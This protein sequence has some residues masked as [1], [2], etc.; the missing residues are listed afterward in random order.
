MDTTGISNGR[1]YLEITTRAAKLHIYNKRPTFR[2]RRVKPVM[3]VEK[4]APTFKVNWLNVR[5]QTGRASALRMAEQQNDE[6]YKK[7]M[8]AIAR[9]SQKGDRLMQIQNK[10]NEFARISR[11]RMREVIPDI[12]IGLMPPQTLQME[13]DIG[14]F[15]IEWSEHAMEIEW[16]VDTSPD[17]YVEPYVVEVRVRNHPP[18]RIKVNRSAVRNTIGG[19]VD[20]KV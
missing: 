13:W 5:A 8:E 18:V 3:R 9:I 7:T 14:Y 2:I 17:I 4:K 16:D 19:K 1:P 10:G 12:N 11:E 6:A 20:K 15:R